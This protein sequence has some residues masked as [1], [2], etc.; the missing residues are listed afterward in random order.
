VLQEHT[1][2]FLRAMVFG[3][4]AFVAAGLVAEP[5]G[6]QAPLRFAVIADYGTNNQ[7]ELD[8]ANLVK[9]WSPDLILTVGDNNH[10]DDAGLYGDADPHLVDV[11]I[12]QY[13]HEYIGNYQGTYGT[14]SPANRF[15]PALGNHD[16]NSTLKYK[17][18]TDYFTLPAGQGN[19]RYYDF[20]QG[21]VHFFV[22]NSESH[23]PGGIGKTSTQAQWLQ[24]AMAASTSSFNFVFLHDPPYTSSDRHSSNTTV[25]WPYKDWGADAVFA[26]HSHLYERLNVGGLSYFVAGVAGEDLAGAVATPV[27]GSQF[28][29][30]TDPDY[31]A[32]QVEVGDSSATFQYY[33]RTGL[34]IDSYSQPAVSNEWKLGAGGS[35]GVPLNWVRNHVPNGADEAANFLRAISGPVTVNSPVTVGT[36]NLQSPGGCALAG[37]AVVTLDSAGG[38]AAIRAQGGDHTISALLSLAVD[39]NI[40]VA[41]GTLTLSGGLDNPAGRTITKDGSAALAVRGPQTHGPGA[42]F[43]AAAGTV[44]FDSDAGAA[45]ALNVS[46]AAVTFGVTQHLAGLNV[47]SGLVTLMSG[48]AKVLVTK[49]LGIAP[50]AATLDLTDNGLIVDY[51]EG[52]PGIPSAVLADVRQGIASGYAGMTWAGGG[53]TSSAAAAD[54]ITCGLGYAQNDLLFDPLDVF[55]GEPVDGS[56][57]LV[58]YTYLGDV[59]LDG[60][61]DENDVTFINVFYDG[62]IT[63]SH[64]WHEGD[65]F[66]YDGR[67]DD[68]DITIL[69]LT[70]GLGI[71]DPLG[72]AA[73]EPATLALVALGALLRMSGSCRRPR[74]RRAPPRGRPSP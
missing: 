55:A 31:G 14:G 36:L 8:V 65:I 70:Y 62:G 53:I 12:G 57:I 69:G 11:N 37:P 28:R 7:P 10:H 47:A 66:G 25:Q 33:T 48:D 21:P 6:A 22:L 54:P 32:M 63:T 13:F 72:G 68:N 60:V 51:A 67:I 3:T 17:T 38:S 2:C 4:T 29:F 44:R 39:T 50:G 73:P 42:V 56:T 46:G 52:E 71:G 15:F 45:L 34:L 1:L 23:E 27:P 19:E 74:P 35:Y 5:A 20:V 43:N 64:S 49:A 58:K 61:V 18:H 24:G 9:G 40:T 16:Y 30:G 26:G 59:N 41:D